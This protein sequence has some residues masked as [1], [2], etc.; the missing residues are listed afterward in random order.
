M[1]TPHF[2]SRTAL[3]LCAAA[4]TSAAGCTAATD[5]NSSAAS[6]PASPST[7]VA[8]A[9]PSPAASTSDSFQERS[10]AWGR[11][12]AACART[13]GLPNFPDPVFTNNY[14]DFPDTP[15]TDLGRA[16]EVCLDIARQQP[17][18]P[19]STRA[20]NATTLRHMRQFSACM[21]QHGLAGFPD[22]RADGT[23]P[24]LNGPYAALAPYSGMTVPQ[25]VM[26]ALNACFQYQVEWRMRA[27]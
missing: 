27:S 1:R 14:V 23:F 10:L 8:T 2:L 25:N 16:Q 4:L 20:P 3:L 13:H 15:K 7:V 26:N 11:Q 21:R 6:P 19:E 22:P 18:Q 9:S 12:F 24:I 17:P 5:T